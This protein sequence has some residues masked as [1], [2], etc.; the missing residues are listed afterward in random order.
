M[1]YRRDIDGLRA[2]AVIPVVI[3][4]IA[5]SFLRGGYVGVDIFFVISGFL[6]S[7]NI[8]TQHEKGSF[9][10]LTFYEH[11]LRRIAPAYIVL[12]LFISVLVAL[13]SLPPETRRFGKTL[14]SAI[15]STTNI[16]FWSTTNYFAVTAEELPLLHTWSLST[17][18]QFY[19]VFPIMIVFIGKYFSIRKIMV[20]FALFF[21]SFVASAIAVY[22]YPVGA[23]YLLPTRAWEL[24]IGTILALEINRRPSEDFTA[25]L[26]H[27]NAVGAHARRL[28]SSRAPLRQRLRGLMQSSENDLIAVLGIILIAVPMVIY[29]PESHFPGLLALPPCLGTALIIYSGSKCQT[30]VACI[31]SSP[32]IRFFGLISYSLYLWHWPILVFQKTMFI[33]TASDSKLIA[34][35]S[36]FFVSVVCATISWWFVERLTRNRALVRS[37]WLIIGSV[38]SALALLLCG[39]IM[40]GSDGLPSR[41]SSAEKAVSAYLDYDQVKQF[42]VGKCFLTRDDTFTLFDQGECLPDLPNRADYL[43]LGDSHAAALSYGLRYTF[44]DANVL[45]V[46]GVGCPPLAVMQS[47]PS[48]A[49]PQLIE[50]A[51]KSIPRSRRISEVWLAARWNLGRLGRAPGWNA[52]W[53]GDLLETVDSLRK[54]NVEV[55]IIGPMPEY[56]TELPRLIVEG[57]HR[58]DPQLPQRFISPDSIKLDS[59][60]EEFAKS[61]K[62][63]YVSLARAICP[64]KRCIETGVGGVPLLFDSDHLTDAG[65]IL[66]SSAIKDHLGAAG[67]RSANSPPVKE[68]QRGGDPAG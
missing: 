13:Y 60:M 56:Q 11:R 37:K 18:E 48:P 19:L 29:N 14:V 40:I 53:L 26:D 38:A 32:P 5:Q 15:F 33:L 46:S 30:F 3:F 16:Y 67:R 8:F 21:T 55:V 24:L 44:P 20:V 23:F 47:D 25:P 35:V 34:R 31:L 62:I 57:I 7:R 68:P 17:E 27:P 59:V 66:V 61:N 2:I 1:Q 54:Q 58:N 51:L 43:I 63:R 49:C 28:A 12:L 36:V 10:L 52:N 39:G 9:K 50:L 65:S 64:N 41:F 45:Q 4:H 42:R 22:V 6:I